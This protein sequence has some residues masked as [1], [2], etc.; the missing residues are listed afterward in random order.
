MKNADGLN[1]A[2]PHM[3]RSLKMETGGG[4]RHTKCMLIRLWDEGDLFL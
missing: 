1:L 4:G 3:E 2:H